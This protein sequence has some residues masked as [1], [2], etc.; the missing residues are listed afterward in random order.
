M[1][2][3]MIAD[4]ENGPVKRRGKTIGETIEGETT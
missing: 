4:E 3:T 2:S 1:E